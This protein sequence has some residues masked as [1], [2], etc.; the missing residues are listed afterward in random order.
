[1]GSLAIA[2]CYPKI[3]QRHNFGKGYFSLCFDILSVVTGQVSF[4]Y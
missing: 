3:I 4:T 2:L 1:M